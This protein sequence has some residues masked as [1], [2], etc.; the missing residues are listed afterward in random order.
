[1][2]FARDRALMV[3]EQLAAR[4]VADPRVLEAF[5][6]VPRER[7]VPEA[8]HAQAYADHPLPLGEGQTISQPFIVALMLQELHLDGH[9]KVLEIGVGSG[10]QTALLASLV[11][12]VYGMER[13]PGLLRRARS[14]LESLGYQNIA[15]RSGDGTLGWREFAPYDAILVSAGAP[16]IPGPLLEQLA[17][18]GRLLIPVGDAE[19]QV[20]YRVTVDEEGPHYEALESCRFVPLI[21]RFGWD[22]EGGERR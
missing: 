21:G 20:L 15:L 22:K 5:R 7:F 13:L 14:T 11:R 8:L 10:Y 1:M 9:E 4:G 12:W 19:G 6:L 18:G 17:P 3:E 2:R 16:E